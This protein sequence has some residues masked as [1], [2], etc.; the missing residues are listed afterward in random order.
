MNVGSIEPPAFN[1][2]ALHI[3]KHQERVS[4]RRI[5]SGIDRWQGLTSYDRDLMSSKPSSPSEEPDSRILRG[6]YGARE[7]GDPGPLY[8]EPKAHLEERNVQGYALKI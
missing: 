2:D 6:Y 8:T 1:K 7:L 5:G 3:P 4:G